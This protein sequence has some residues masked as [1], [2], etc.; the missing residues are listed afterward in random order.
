[1]IVVKSVGKKEE[2]R[3]ESEPTEVIR[4]CLHFYVF[5]R[6]LNFYVSCHLLHST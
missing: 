5:R 4:R 1:M 6:Y 3:K 2:T